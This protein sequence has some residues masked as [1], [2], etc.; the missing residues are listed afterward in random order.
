MV[1]SYTVIYI[2]V[3]TGGGGVH[4][5]LLVSMLLS[6]CQLVVIQSI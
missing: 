2:Y 5:H 1:H 6:F 4:L 3:H